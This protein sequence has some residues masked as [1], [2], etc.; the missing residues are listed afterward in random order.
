MAK[1]K[2]LKKRRVPAQKKP[3]PL[4]K[5]VQALLRYLGGT[6][7]K[8]SSSARQPATIAPQFPQQAGQGQ[9]QQQQQ[10]QA[11]QQAPRRQR[12]QTGNVVALSPL[13]QL[14]PA[15]LPPVQLTPEQEKAK[16]QAE[17]EAKVKYEA[18]QKAK[19]EAT[20]KVSQLEQSLTQF[21]QQAI[22]VAGGQLNLTRKLQ[23]EVAALKSS[24]HYQGQDYEPLDSELDFTPSSKPFIQEQKLLVSTESTPASKRA[25]S[26]PT[27]AAYEPKEV[28]IGQAAHA[29]S[30]YIQSV[31]SPEM[32]PKVV[33]KGK[34]GRPRLSD[35]QKAANAEARKLEKKQKAELL[36]Q[37][38]QQLYEGQSATKALETL[39]SSLQAKKAEK[40]K[41][42]LK[43]P[44]LTGLDPSTQIE[45]LASAGGAAAKSI[46]PQRGMSIPEL[47]KSD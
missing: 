14:A 11:P 4:P 22:D 19:E 31:A 6:D 24:Q 40:I 27:R 16:L 17:A 15:P 20:A 7:V 9:P 23:N 8:M 2:V 34:A 3:Q 28:D 38:G 35:E 45:Q 44:S 12:K 43:T 32:T 41:L 42:K 36:K 21:K 46:S 47:K 33:L 18:K 10:Q 39:T 37:A 1:K 5:S 26:A 13:G 25:I 29:A 30:Q